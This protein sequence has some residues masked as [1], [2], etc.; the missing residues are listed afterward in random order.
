MPQL[1]IFMRPRK[2]SA[3]KIM[4]ILFFII[5]L[6]AIGLWFAGNYFY[7]YAIKAMPYEERIADNDN[8]PIIED[9][10]ITELEITSGD[11]LNLVAYEAENQESDHKWVIV[12]HGYKSAAKHME[13][14]I[15]NFYKS[16][17]SVLAP[18]LRGQGAS[19]GSYIGMGYKDRL[20]VIDWAQSIID[21]DDSAE[22][23]L[24]GVSMGGSTVMMASGEDLPINIKS[25]I[26]DCGYASLYDEFSHQ[27]KEQFGL[28]GFPVINAADMITRIK[29]GYTFEEASAFNAVGRSV[30]PILFI[31]GTQDDY[32]PFSDLQRLYDNASCEKDMLMVEGAGHGESEEIAGEEYWDII[33]SFMDEHGE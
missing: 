3:G 13:K 27:L 2:I 33:K 12:V 21:K 30:T 20:D 7:D 17:Y 10:K 24:F 19:E 18:D 14:Y 26:S 23:T 6:I 15:D 31:H 29:A 22:I 8:T 1:E 28:P 5:L 25:I 16:G 4:I 32:V 9:A 11:G